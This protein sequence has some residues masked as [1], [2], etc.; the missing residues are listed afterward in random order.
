VI[1]VSEH[2]LVRREQ[3]Q[4]LGNP[5]ALTPDLSVPL[6]TNEARN[7]VDVAKSR[8]AE[9]YAPEIFSKANASLQMM[10]QAL[11]RKAQTVDTISTARARRRSLLKTRV[12]WQSLVKRRN[13]SKTIA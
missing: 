10:E 9:K 7:A 11:V 3:Y 1:P 6:D 12:L 8:G 13:V 5:L 4:K 2:R